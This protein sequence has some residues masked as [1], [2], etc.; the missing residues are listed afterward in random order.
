MLKDPF[1]PIKPEMPPLRVEENE[2]LLAVI[3][4]YGTQGWR[5]AQAT[6]TYLLKNAAGVGYEDA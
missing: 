1:T 4:G 5:D 2:L 3:H 6:Q